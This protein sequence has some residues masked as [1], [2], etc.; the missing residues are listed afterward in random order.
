MPPRTSQRL[1][2]TWFNKDKAL[3]PAERGKY[4]YSWVDP[5]DPR[6]CEVRTLVETAVVQGAE[7]EK[8]EG[9]EYTERADLTPTTDNLLI[10]GDSG[11]V[12]EALHHVPEL[13][14]KYA[15]KIKLFYADPPFN[16]EKRFTHY[17]DNLEHSI[18][19]TM[20]RDRLIH[21]RELLAAD[22]SVWIHLDDSENHR[23]R[24]LLDEVFSPGA[25]VAEIAWQKRTSRDNRAAFSDSHDY[26]LVYAPAGSQRWKD[27]RNRLVDSGEFSNPDNDPNGP[28]RSVP[29]SAQAGRATASQFWTVVTPTGVRHDP[30]PGRAWTYT[31]ERFQELVDKGWVYWPKNGDGKP[32]LKKYPTE[33]DG[34]VPMTWW[35]SDETGT[36]DSAKKGLMN[37]FPGISDI[38]DTPK[39][40]T[41]LERIVHIATDPGDVVLDVFAGSGTTAAVAHKMGRRWVTA[42]LVEETIQRFTLPRLQMVVSGEDPGGITTTSAERVDDSEDGLPE[43]LSAPEAHT[44]NQALTKASKF[45][46]APVDIGKLVQDAVRVDRATEQPALDAKEAKELRRLIDKLAESPAAQTDLLPHLRKVVGDQLRTRKG[47]GSMNW[48]GGGSF[49]VM[50]LS[51]TV[52]DYDPRLG[53][54]MLTDAAHG[55]T[56]VASI[57]ANLGFERTPGAHP[58]HGRKGKMRLVVLEGAVTEQVVDDVLAHLPSG[59]RV[60]IAALSVPDGVRKYLRQRSRGSVVK[61]VPDDLFS[62]AGNTSTETLE[63]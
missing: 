26:I 8:V 41:L 7:A 36:T 54:V 60:T 43:G 38:F 29:M 21:V 22:G 5:K 40:E 30:P 47:S 46:S 42:E 62:F 45:V 57:A 34:L 12:L 25:F 44:I 53:L 3:I 6:Y 28:W 17:E 2:L 23:M 33:D 51:P 27:V 50:E 59:E 20:M 4:G 63:G 49:R 10:H 39:P 24:A 19:L 48:R 61:H 16:T 9:V 1:E 58:F 35:P 52:F 11:D 32:R 15:G 18:W 56:L 13:A 14:S 37:L 55:E 31:R